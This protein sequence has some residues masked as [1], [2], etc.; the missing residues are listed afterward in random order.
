MEPHMPAPQASK[1]CNADQVE[2]FM[3]YRA[4]RAQ[5]WHARAPQLS[6]QTGISLPRVYEILRERRWTLK[7]TAPVESGDPL[8]LT[9]EFV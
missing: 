5:N 7:T 6:K 8:P 4:A 1:I 9:A 3:L 2:P